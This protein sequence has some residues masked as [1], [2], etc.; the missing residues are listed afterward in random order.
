LPATINDLTTGSLITQIQAQATLILAKSTAAT[1]PGAA[2]VAAVA[3]LDIFTFVLTIFYLALAIWM[4]W[5]VHLISDMLV[6]GS[7][8]GKTLNFVGTGGDVGKA[9]K[10]ALGGGGGKSGGDKQTNAMNDMTKAMNNLAA[11]MKKP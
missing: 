3:V 11:S 9:I 2:T 1:N 6:A 7:G 8:V 5:K 10:Q 4:M